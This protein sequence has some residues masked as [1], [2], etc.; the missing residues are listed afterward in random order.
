MKLTNVTVHKYKSYDQQQSFPVDDDI[1]IIV[2][3]NESGK[4][5]ILEAIAKTNYFSNDND[6]KFNPTHDYPRKEK[7][8]YDKSGEI[9]DAITCTYHLSDGEIK[10]IEQ[11]VGVNTVDEWEFSVTTKYDN[12]RTITSPKINI[13]NFLEFIGKKYSLDATNLGLIKKLT[14]KNNIL[15]TIDEYKDVDE[16]SQEGKLLK[17]LNDIKSNYFTDLDWDNW[18]AAYLWRHH[19]SPTIPKF[20]YFDEYYELPSKIDL[21]NIN[22][23]TT[24]DAK[25][26]RALLELADVDLKDLQHPDS[27]EDFKAELEATSSEITQHI[28]KYWRNNTGLRVQFDIESKENR[29]Y[30]NNVEKNLNIRVWSDKH[31]ISLPLSNRS[32]GF[33]WFFSF[34]VWFSRIQEDKSNQYIL[35]LD[36]PGLNLHAA[37]Q[38][39]LLRFLDDLSK[40]YQIIYTTHSPF[41]VPH[42]S[43]ERVRTVYE[44][45][46]GTTIKDAIEEKDSDT[47]F[48]LQAALGYDIAQNLFINKNN[49][50][51]EGV[52]DLVYLTMMSSILEESGLQGIKNDITIV[53]IGG[54]DKVTSFISLLKGQN[55]NI[56]CALDTFTDQKGKARLNSLIE[57]KIIKE[58]NVLFFN[59]FSRNVGDIADLEDMFDINEYLNF[60]NSAFNEYADID[61]SDIDTSKPIIQQINKIIQ[62]PR[63]NHYRPSMAANKLGLSKDNFSQET[64][65]RFEKLFKK[66]NS[67]F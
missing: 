40:E 52:S 66:I 62:K 58:K 42:N 48:P 17:S 12:K 10:K 55:L 5:T 30:P 65:D 13:P 45:K 46:D 2:G 7:K 26:A 3:K 21:D 56:V 34:I 63:Y 33:N 11:L 36:E 35:L 44:S 60:F 51:V 59:H 27:Y 29:S 14:N 18:L 25:T 28:F 43:L 9:G 15:S 61:E 49:L 50:L 16:I 38:A 8:K 4:T 41:M 57:Q 53:P 67:L 64:L 39:D 19:F 6:F 23:S 22:K 47:L 37:A 20:M 1:T 54:L 24:Q 31:H 32:K